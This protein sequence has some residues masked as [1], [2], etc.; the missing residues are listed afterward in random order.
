MGLNEKFFSSSTADAP[1][2]FGPRV[3]LDAS[4]SSSYPGTGS[5]WFDL[6]NNYN[7]NMINTQY[8]ALDGGY[9]EFNGSNAYVQTPYYVTGASSISI[10]QWVKAD[11]VGTDKCTNTVFFNGG[12][13]IDTMTAST[14]S[15]TSTASLNSINLAKTDF[16]TAWNHVVV[17]LSGLA[18]TYNTGGT[19]AS[20]INADI[21]YNGV[22]M[23]RVNPRPYQIT[24]LNF[25][26]GKNGG[27]WYF[28]GKIAKVRLYDKALTATEIEALHNEGR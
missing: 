18:S 27:A 26:I 9:M 16:R 21:Y 22:F 3:Y 24:N 8:S 6:A 14:S 4:N 10:E 12:G 11:T 20:A 28:D 25:R 1:V 17:V 7:G 15:N 5:T 19:W 13:R 23:Q 2:D